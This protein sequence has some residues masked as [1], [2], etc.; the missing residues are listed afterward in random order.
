M[1]RAILHGGCYPTH[2][3]RLYRHAKGCC[4][5]RLDNQHFLVNGPTRVLPGDMM[6]VLMSDLTTWLVR[7]ARWAG[8]EAAQLEDRSQNGVQLAGRVTGN[9]QERRRWFKLWYGRAPLFVRAFAYFGF[10]YFLR[11]GFLDGKEGL[12][13][14]F[15]H[16][17]FYRFYVDAKIYETR[18]DKASLNGTAVAVP[19]NGSPQKRTEVLNSV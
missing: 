9:P 8:L 5:D 3:L 11:L 1:G 19:P 7:H 15:L 17:C 14:H 10:R 6:D 4:E 12:I 13:F 16:G 18:K 2:H